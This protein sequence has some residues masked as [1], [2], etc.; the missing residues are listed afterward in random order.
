MK[1]I[2]IAIGAYLVSFCW[3]YSG[4]AK[5]NSWLEIII[6]EIQVEGNGAELFHE[7]SEKILKLNGAARGFKKIRFND[8]VG[9]AVIKKSFTQSNIPV[10]KLLSVIA[11]QLRAEWH[12][13]SGRAV[14][15]R[16]TPEIEF[17]FSLDEDN[18]DLLGLDYTEDRS[19]NLKKFVR[20]LDELGSQIGDEQIK[21]LPERPVH[22]NRDLLEI[23]TSQRELEYLMSLIKV[24]ERG[25]SI[26]KVR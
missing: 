23:T 7:I 17:Y 11:D 2:A 18:M 9:I 8:D 14:F 13:Y 16:Y 10:G 4:E 26:E 25:L 5:E 21:E 22:K 1:S 24:L 20:R 3:A 19:A 6:P 12:N 15:Y